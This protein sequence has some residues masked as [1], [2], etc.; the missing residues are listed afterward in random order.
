MSA[1]A[2]NTPIRPALVAAKLAKIRNF[3]DEWL[4]LEISEEPRLVEALWFLQFIS[5]PNG[6]QLR[7]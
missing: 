7:E 2:E 1:P 3:E 6:A 5:D 4:H